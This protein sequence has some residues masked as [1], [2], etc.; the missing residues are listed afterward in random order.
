MKVHTGVRYAIVFFCQGVANARTPGAVHANLTALGFRLP[1]EAS[2]RPTG[3]ERKLV[4]LALQG[5]P[6]KNE[7]GHSTLPPLTAALRST[8][9]TWNEL[10]PMAISCNM[11]L[12]FHICG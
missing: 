7:P 11:E 5:I 3:T 4:E 10:P 1:A 2:L 6:V 9:N 12:L 8:T